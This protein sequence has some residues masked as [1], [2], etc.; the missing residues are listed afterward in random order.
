MPTNVT[1]AGVHK[2]TVATE[3]DDHPDG[4]GATLNTPCFKHTYKSDWSDCAPCP[5]QQQRPTAPADN[6][7]T[8]LPLIHSLLVRV[9][10][11]TSCG[12]G[13]SRQ[14]AQHQ[15]QH[16][17]TTITVNVPRGSGLEAGPPYWHIILSARCFSSYT[18]YMAITI[19]SSLSS[20]SRWP[21]MLD[22]LVISST[23]EA[24]TLAEASSLSNRAFSVLA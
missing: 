21:R 22:F 24:C 23:L 1:K 15:H 5:L 9:R 17:I 4:Q 8:W 2:R 7:A 19:Y 13:C 20:P 6:K 18:R 10:P 14:H 12:Y 11:G 3:T 16:P